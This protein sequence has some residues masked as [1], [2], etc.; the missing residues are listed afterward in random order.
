M[1]Y[2]VAEV[3]K[4]NDPIAARK[5]GV[6]SM[7]A[8][9]VTDEE[10]EKVA[11]ITKE[12]RADN[13][14]IMSSGANGSAT[15]AL[16]GDY[17]DRPLPTP[18]RTPI[19]T[20]PSSQEVIMREASNLRMLERGQTPLLGGSNPELKEG[21]SADGMALNRFTSAGAATPMIGG[22]ETPMTLGGKSTDRKD[23]N[24]TPM[25]ASKRDELGLNRPH[26]NMHPGMDAGD[27]ISIS[28]TSFA[29]SV[30]GNSMS[31]KEIARAERRAA[32]RARK[33]L[34]MALANLP[35]PQFEYELAI[36][37]AV[38]DDERDDSK[39]TMEKDA[40]E[41]EAEEFARLEREAAELYAKRSSVV[42]RLD[43][44][45]PIGA[46]NEEL[47]FNN[48]SKENE[49]SDMNK[50]AQELINKELLT[51]LQH[52]AFTHPYIKAEEDM[53][54][55]KSKKDKKGKKKGKKSQ[56]VSNATGPP[57][58]PLQHFEEE[59]LDIAKSM[60]DE[61][62]ETV[63][64]EKRS[65]A[66]NSHSSFES[67][68]A[69]KDLLKKET[70]NN[71]IN[72]SLD[73]VYIDTDNTNKGWVASTDLKK[74]LLSSLQTEYNV[75]VLSVE[76]IRKRASKLESKISIKNGGY[77][78]RSAAMLQSI[79]KDFAE[80]QNS[81]IEE[82]VFSSLMQYESRGISTRI[83]KLQE[84]TEHLEQEESSLQKKYGDLLHER[85]RHKILIRQKEARGKN[86]DKS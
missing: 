22:S 15:D 44:P 72:S 63:I 40:A 29:T 1:Q 10:L 80:F 8:P 74:D 60:L 85:N 67:D 42:K 16:L 84:E 5:R 73:H 23:F 64:Q 38:T 18:M 6:L 53:D 14:A 82:N 66:S 41:I 70:I 43:L 58:T 65:N 3:S 4:K 51:L 13:S 30:G 39:V 2:V 81:V 71:C 59:A 86:C 28:A 32:K 17:T 21:E 36:P 62:F 76:A 79:S 50:K 75:T 56:S 48:A 27:D 52:D 61:E 69:V 55:K 20:G 35:A 45:R 68:E 49:E 57:D 24:H 46:I 77:T 19:G 37:G 12:Q 11:K 83:E 78:K 54:I 33:E 47:I 31:I 9:S 26:S 25:T 7:P 34:E